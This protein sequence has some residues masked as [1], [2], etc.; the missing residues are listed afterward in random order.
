MFSMNHKIAIGAIV[1]GV[2]V[3]FTAP[4]A[5]YNHKIDTCLDWYKTNS[6]ATDWRSAKSQFEFECQRMVNGLQ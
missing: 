4:A 5:Y 1:A 6:G 3:A 2:V